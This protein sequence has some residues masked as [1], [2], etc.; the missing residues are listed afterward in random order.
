MA[1]IIDAGE[2]TKLRSLKKALVKKL[3]VDA[4]LTAAS[5][6]ALTEVQFQL[7]AAERRVRQLEAQESSLRGALEEGHQNLVRTRSS[8]DAAQAGQR[9]AEATVAQLRAQLTHLSASCAEKDDALAAA[10]ARAAQVTEDL[11]NAQQAL[12]TA[13][14]ELAVCIV[15]ARARVCVC[16]CVCVHTCTHVCTWRACCPARFCTH[17]CVCVHVRARTVWCRK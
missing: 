13:R 14:A 4:G 15:H 8:L 10:D 12:R 1:V 11:S 16:V 3:G 2:S 7:A 17:T 6:R 5:K 9:E